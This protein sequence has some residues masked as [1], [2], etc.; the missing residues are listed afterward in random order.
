MRVICDLYFIY[1]YYLLLITFFIGNFGTL[2]RV[3]VLWAWPSFPT[4][5]ILGKPLCMHR[6]GKNPMSYLTPMKLGQMTPFMRSLFNLWDEN[7]R[8]YIA[9]INNVL[10]ALGFFDWNTFFIL[11]NALKIL[12]S[13]KWQSPISWNCHWWLIFTSSLCVLTIPCSSLSRL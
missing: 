2:E 10:C 11:V 5:N 8:V 12:H 9:N 7:T 6:L 13:N 3:V 1:S 4:I